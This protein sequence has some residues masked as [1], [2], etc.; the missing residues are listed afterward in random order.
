MKIDVAEDDDDEQIP[1]TTTEDSNEVVFEAIVTEDP[2]EYYYEEEEGE[3]EGDYADRNGLMDFLSKN[4]ERVDE[5]TK[6]RYVRKS[7]IYTCIPRMEGGLLR[8]QL[9]LLVLQ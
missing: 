4:H 8:Q 3:E 2:E 1:T 5:H 9:R 6:T 7:W